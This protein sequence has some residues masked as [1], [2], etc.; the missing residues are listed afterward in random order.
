MEALIK[1]QVVS[2]NYDNNPDTLCN[3]VRKYHHFRDEDH[4]LRGVKQL[5]QGH[6][7]AMGQNHD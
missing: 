3:P 7:T 1:F 5:A 6:T 4:E 2:A